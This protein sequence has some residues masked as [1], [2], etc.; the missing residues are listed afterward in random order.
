[1]DKLLS[2]QPHISIEASQSIKNDIQA[3]KQISKK[4]NIQIK[5]I[6]LINNTEALVI[7]KK[8]NFGVIVKGIE[9]SQN[10]FIENS[11][12]RLSLI[13]ISEPTRPY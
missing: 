10:F 3:I 7:T 9:N 11:I 6:N 8:D 2:Y 5:N 1:M 12:V 13:H 4:Q